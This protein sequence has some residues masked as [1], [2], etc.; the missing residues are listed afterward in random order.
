MVVEAPGY[1]R[2]P[3]SHISQH[4]HQHHRHHHPPQ[5][6]H[7]L[8]HQLNLNRVQRAQVALPARLRRA[9]R[10]WRSITDDPKVL[11]LVD[12]GLRFELHRQPIGP[13]KPPVFNGSPDVMRSLAEQLHAW[14]EQGI[15]EPCTD[16]DALFSLLFPVPKSGGRWRWVLDSR[17]LNEAIVDRTFKMES[18]DVV[19]RMLRKNDWM[20]SIDL[21]DA[22]LHVPINRAHRRYLAFR[23]FNRNFQFAAMS[24]GTKCAPRTF[25]KLMKPVLAQLHR[26]NIRCSIYMDDLILAASDELASARATQRALSLIES[27]GLIVNYEKSVLMPTQ[28][29]VH[30]GL[31][32]DSRAARLFVPA[33]KLRASARTA[34]QVLDLDA[35]GT[36]TVRALARL[37][38]VV[39]SFMPALRAAWRRRHSIVRCVQ[40][41]LRASGGN[42]DAPVSLSRT[43]LNDVEFWASSAPRRHNGQ[44]FRPSQPEATLTTDAS[45]WGWGAVLTT[46]DGAQYTTQAAWTRAEANRSSNWR[47]S[48][49]IQHAFDHFRRRIR[50]LRCLL[51]QSDNST[52]VSTLRRFGSRHKHLDLALQ[53]MLQRV[54]AWRLEL[55][56]EHIAGEHNTIADRLSRN[57]M[58][59]RNEWRLSDQAMRMIVRRFGEPT[60]DWF[61]SPTNHRC[62]RFAS[63]HSEPQRPRAVYHDAMSV[64]WSKD[65]GLFVP[66]INMISRVMNRI[67]E[68]RARG[69]MVV[70]AWFSQHWAARVPWRSRDSIIWLPQSAMR[71]ASEPA[72]RDGRAT[73][74]VAFLI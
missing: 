46:P 16:E 58:T 19:R 62:P 66:P 39:V 28:R 6:H 22:F 45:E 51:V 21:K 23:A 56:V 24:L 74:L 3:A 26:E 1:R 61:A 31:T 53:P 63:W 2:S 4:H 73:Q 27:L 17:R 9:R 47:E 34:R 5:H 40:F 69:I 44:P 55:R 67:D 12:T 7:L 18:V 50:P 13:R 42:W 33:D 59:E 35:R 36:L 49:A 29:I 41:G 38:G 48:T 25:T 32:F 8:P 37:S 20:T 10:R 70:P 43:A 57:L 68:Q 30:L 71:S 15:I 14:L 72:M 52:A 64:D 65:F 11:E 54:L 60:I